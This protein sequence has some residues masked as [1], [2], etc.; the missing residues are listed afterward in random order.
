MIYHMASVLFSGLLRVIGSDANTFLARRLVR[1]DVK[2]VNFESI[3]SQLEQ[4]YC[5]LNLTIMDFEIVIFL[6]TC[7]I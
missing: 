5:K 7:L 1:H 3:Q 6:K 4:K 2:Y